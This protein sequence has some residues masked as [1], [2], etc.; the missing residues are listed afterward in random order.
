MLQS[1]GIYADFQC[2]VI[3]IQIVRSVLLLMMLVCLLR[4]SP[5]AEAASLSSKAGAV[6]TQGTSLNVRNAPSSGA[7]VVNS[8]KKGSYITLIEKVGAWWRVE[9][10]NEKYGY[11]HGDYITI[12]QGS[13]VMVNTQSGGL[14]VRSGPGTGYGKTATLAKKE[15]VLL[16]STKNGW[17]RV[18]YHGT[19]T[20][21]V[22]AQYLSGYY[23]AV[24]LAVPNFKQADARWADVEIGNSGKTMAQIG[25][26]TTAITMME[27]AR[28]GSTVYPDSM[29]SQLRYTDSGNVYWPGHYQA[30]TQSD[31]YLSA[32][33]QKLRQGKPVLFGARNAYGAQ[34][35]VVITGFAGGTELTAQ[36]FMI[37]DPGSWSRTNLH[38]FLKDFPTFY[39]YFYY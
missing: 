39:K 5:G 12:V 31:G 29:V 32:I 36:G 16:L 8:L 35:W 26:A 7:T 3:V 34:H 37:Q 18:L 21:F 19:K 4:L 6:T 20:G 25:C 22:S 30:V 24:S 33:Y 9:Y 10:A 2:E 28:T 38:L 15:A 13:P 23:G 14:N 11:C 17:S 1:P 27:S